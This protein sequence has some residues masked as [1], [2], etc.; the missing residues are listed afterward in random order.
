MH[1]LIEEAYKI[2]NSYRIALYDLEA[3]EVVWT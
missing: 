3:R 2:E 1:D